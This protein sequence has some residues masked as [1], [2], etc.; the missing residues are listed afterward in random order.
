MPVYQRRIHIEAFA[1]CGYGGLVKTRALISQT[2]LRNQVKAFEMD[3]ASVSE[4]TTVSYLYFGLLKYEVS[5]K[6]GF[7]FNI[8]GL[9][10]RQTKT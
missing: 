10:N 1:L 6:S 9:L 2:S 5:M 7:Y 4:R 8:E 3:R